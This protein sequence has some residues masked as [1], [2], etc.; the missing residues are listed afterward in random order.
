ME[1]FYFD[2]ELVVLINNKQY[3]LS[4]EG[5]VIY[6]EYDTDLKYTGINKIIV[7]DEE[8][9]IVNLYTCADAEEIINYAMEYKY[10]V[11]YEAEGL[12]S[13]YDCLD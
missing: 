5:S 6:D 12:E 13:W 10:E 11:E 8:D 2:K 1:K 9:K 4:V 3:Y 7:V